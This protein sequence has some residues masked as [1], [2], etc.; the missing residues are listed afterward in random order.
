MADP[1]KAEGLVIAYE[2]NG[3]SYPIACAK[4]STITVN[5]EFMELAPKTN[6]IF[7]QYI[8]NRK[9]FTISG[10]GLIK[11]S[12]SNKNTFDFFEPFLIGASLYPN[13]QYIIK[14]ETRTNIGNMSALPTGPLSYT[15]TN[16]QL[17]YTNYEQG[18]P[19]LDSDLKIFKNGTLIVTKVDNGT[20]TL[21]LAPGD[22]I[23]LQTNY[24]T[25]WSSTGYYR[26]YVFNQTDNVMLYNTTYANPVAGDTPIHNYTF[27]AVGGTVGGTGIFT[28]YLE[29]LDNLNNYDVYQ[30][31][32]YISSLTLE[33]TYGSTPT[34]SYN[35]QGTGP[36]TKI[37]EANTATVDSGKITARS[38]ATYKLLALGY[39][40]AWYYDY[41]VTSP[42][43]GVY[44][45]NLGT[46]LNGKSVRTV[47]KTL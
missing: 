28:A 13:K 24:Y 8:P 25:T 22:V 1:I 30:M 6:N 42:S 37:S 35:L 29:M 17:T 20:A 19:F 16:P 45:I 21:T 2:S 15:G 33:S 27:T 31:Q 26:L 23:K 9:S 5:G 39:D 18:S 36:L 47:Y 43:T 32:C 7:R 46:A 34:Y 44:E 11:L 4:N 10:S 3:V 14:A 41:I 40:G 38:T 12:E